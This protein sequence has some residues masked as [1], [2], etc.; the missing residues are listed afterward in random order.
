MLHQSLLAW[1]TLLLTVS[2]HFNLQYPKARGDDE[3]KSSSGPCGTFDT[4]STDRTPVSLTSLAIGAKMGH[5]ES[6]FSIVLGLGNNPSSFNISLLP[7]FRQEGLGEF[8]LPDVPIP[9]DLGLQDGAN[10]TVQVITNGDPNGGLYAVCL[11]SER[12]AGC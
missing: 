7:T 3:D 5:D 12:A 9:G 2:A 6:A 8:C 10:G 11:P 1:S 4:P